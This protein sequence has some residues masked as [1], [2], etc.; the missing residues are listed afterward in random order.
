MYNKQ[1][2]QDRLNEVL[3]EEDIVKRFYHFRSIQN[4]ISSFD[5]LGSD[6]KQKVYSTLI[7]YLQKIKQEPIEDMHQSTTLFDEYIRPVGNLYEKNLGFMPMMSVW[8]ICF[9][10]IVLFG[11]MFI[12]R[13][14]II[15]YCVIGILLASYYIY[16][17]KKRTEKK[18]Y[19]LKW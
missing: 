15:F 9:W 3:L 16:L 6:Q 17:L 1:D 19:G 7:E 5:K 13:L 14:S 11:I 18:V 10:V 4:F 12:F 2:I 8:V